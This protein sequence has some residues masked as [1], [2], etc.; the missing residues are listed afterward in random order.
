LADAENILFECSWLA[1]G[2]HSRH[3][4]QLLSHGLADLGY[5]WGDVTAVVVACGPGSFSGVRVAIS[6]G[7][8]LAMA[9]EIPLVGISTLDVVGYQAAH[10]GRLVLATLSAGRGQL[11][12]AAYGG[13]QRSWHRVG[14]YRLAGVTELAVDLLPGTYLAG[15]GTDALAA[16]AAARAG[17]VEVQPSSDRLRR[18]G[19]LAELGREHLEEGGSD[20]VDQLE[21]MYLRMSAAE[22]NFAGS[23]QV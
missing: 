9:R 20:Q 18:A 7:K 10:E 17:S 2:N 13:S 11:F 8:G 4:H 16:A 14:E 23:P 22:E 19:Y 12:A 5:A 3:L 1:G 6:A 21:P 15:E